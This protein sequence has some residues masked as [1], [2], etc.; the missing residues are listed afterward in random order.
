M[1]QDKRAA[2]PLHIFM[3]PGSGS[4]PA[5]S[6]ITLEPSI[7]DQP[8]PQLSFVCALQSYVPT[9]SPGLMFAVVT[10]GPPKF[11]FSQVIVVQASVLVFIWI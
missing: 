8:A 1:V 6:V 2:S 5:L 11:E 9:G 3:F 7:V 4:A 10:P